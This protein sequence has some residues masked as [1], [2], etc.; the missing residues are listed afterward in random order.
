MI[1]CF[2]IFQLCGDDRT[3]LMHA[4]AR[5]DVDIVKLLLEH[6]ADVNA[7]DRSGETALFK[8][9]DA[10]HSQVVEL[11]LRHEPSVE[12]VANFE[13]TTNETGASRQDV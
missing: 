11:L 7:K 13:Q 3:F 5:G 8:A 1:V 9:M 10:G 2:E 6:E 12:S 4:A